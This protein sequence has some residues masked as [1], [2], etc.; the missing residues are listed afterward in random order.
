MEHLRLRF[1]SPNLIHEGTTTVPIP[2]PETYHVKNSDAIM[3]LGFGSM[4][5]IPINIMFP[6]LLVSEHDVAEKIA[7]YGQNGEMNWVTGHGQ[8]YDR[9]L[10]DGV[11]ITVMNLVGREVTWG[12]LRSVLKGLQEFLVD[13]NRSREVMFRFRFGTGPEVGWGYIARN[14]GSGG[15][16]PRPSHGM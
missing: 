1:L 11:R 2:L 14:S 10:G 13:G 4:A 6:L 5:R 15:W 3:R 12:E 7:R 9:D 8:M 16:I